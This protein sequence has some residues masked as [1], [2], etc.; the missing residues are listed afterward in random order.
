[1]VRLADIF[2]GHEGK[3]YGSTPGDWS[4]ETVRQLGST[5]SG[6]TADEIKTLKLNSTDVMYS[7]GKHG[8]LSGTKLVAGFGRW[9][10][11]A[12]GGDVSKLSSAELKGMG[13]F[14]CGAT[15]DQIENITAAAYAGAANTIGGLDSCA[16]AQVTGFAQKAKE[17]YG[18]D[19]SKWS[20]SV[21]KDMGNMVG[22][23][24][25]SDLAKLSTDQISVIS[26]T[27]IKNI[28]P[29]NFA[30]FTAEQ[31]LG[32]STNQAKSV[33]NDQLLALEPAQVEALGTASGGT[34]TV[35]NNN[36]GG[37]NGEGGGNAAPETV[38]T[39]A[40]LIITSALL[41]LAWSSQTVL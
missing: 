20:T 23:L 17:V 27:S 9:A 36:G 21:V 24:G 18:D 37:N 41:A 19:V 34:I 40:M 22:G 15:A 14:P 32:M 8:K 39:S 6:L 25:K 16:I 7:I 31:L 35:V 29:V 10:E 28:P 12:K 3:A 38:S 2:T 30:G 11:L 1:M 13:H 26:T 5:V 33:E 4:S